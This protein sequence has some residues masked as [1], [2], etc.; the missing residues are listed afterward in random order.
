[1]PSNCQQRFNF[2]VGI[3]CPPPSFFIPLPFPST[4]LHPFPSLS[5]TL[6]LHVS[7]PFPFTF[8]HPFPSRSSNLS[9]HFSPPLPHWAQLIRERSVQITIPVYLNFNS[10]YMNFDFLYLNFDHLYLNV[11]HLNLNFDHLYLNFDH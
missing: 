11:D 5:S 3:S 9:L 8:L 7:P 10:V 4:F 1:M 6:Y 2:Q